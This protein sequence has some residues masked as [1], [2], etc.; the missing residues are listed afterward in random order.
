MKVYIEKAVLLLI[1]LF[2]IIALT[3]KN[4]GSAILVLL[5]L[6]SLFFVFG[7]FKKLGREE[8]LLLGA[9]FLFFLATCISLFETEHL[10]DGLKRLE[11]IFR[12]VFV[13]PIFLMLVKQDRD[14]GKYF[15]YGVA[16]AGYAIFFQTFYQIY[17]LGLAA[18]QGA[19]HQI[20]F[21]EYAMLVF[22]ILILVSLVAKNIGIPRFQQLL[23]VTGAILALAV[24]VK[25]ESKGAWL[26]LPFVALLFLLVFRSRLTVQNG[27]ISFVVF[28]AVVGAAASTS[29]V[30]SRLNL[31]Y[32]DYEAYKLNPRIEGTLST[33]LNMWRDSWS[34]FVKSPLLGT[35]MGDYK[36][37]VQGLM[38]DKISYQTDGSY[39]HPHSIYFDILAQSGIIGFSAMIFALIVLPFRYFYRSWKNGGGGWQKVYTVCGMATVVSYSAFGL[40]ESWISQNAPV[41]VYSIFITIFVYS[42]YKEKISARKISQK[43]LD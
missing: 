6:I 13:I 14:I 4:A 26:A 33:R 32:Q 27:V 30:Q 43:A 16:L 23:L 8:R 28:A 9:F 7:I 24:A 38:A 39:S 10:E 2:P 5:F 3:V 41:N 12:F 11:R 25:S 18:A 20:L 29:S 17:F 42:I 36:K 22:G 40:S 21:G 35:G 1:T 31:L 34:I 15:V 37:D 19:Y